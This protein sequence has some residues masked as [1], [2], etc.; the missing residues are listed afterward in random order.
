MAPASLVDP[1]VKTCKGSLRS[2]TMRIRTFRVQIWL[3]ILPAHARRQ[4]VGAENPPAIIPDTLGADV[5]AHR[6]CLSIVG[7]SMD[8]GGTAVESFISEFHLPYLVLMP[9]LALPSAPAVDA[10]PTTVLLDR[11]G[12]STKVLHRRR[13]GVRASG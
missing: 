9:D 2:R 12:R 5:R 13:A 11:N 8:A 3:E 10:L 7:F 1:I 4:A 6:K